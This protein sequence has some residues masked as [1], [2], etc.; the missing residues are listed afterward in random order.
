MPDPSPGFG[1]VA[2]SSGDEVNMAMEDRLP[3]NGPAVHAHVE[4]LHRHIHLH[5]GQSG[6]VQKLMAGKAFFWS[7]PEVFIHMT[8]WYDQGV[9]GGDREGII[10]G[11]GQGIFMNDPVIGK[12][13]EKA[14]H[15]WLLQGM[16]LA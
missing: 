1:Y 11:N 13:T 16:I 2:L 12:V 14:C 4:T 3:G 10:Y 9:M 5:D 15:P 7:Q 8:S 6:A